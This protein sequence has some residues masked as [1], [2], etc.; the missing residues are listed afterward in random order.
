MKRLP[1]H[2][3][4]T[5]AAVLT[6]AALLVF[7]AGCGGNGGAAPPTPTVTVTAPPGTSST[8]EVPSSPAETSPP[9]GQPPSA[10]QSQAIWE[11]IL[12]R[13]LAEPE[14]AP[15]RGLDIQSQGIKV[16]ADGSD[17]VTAVTLFNDEAALGYGVSG[18]TYRAYAGVLP[19]GLT[20]SSTDSDVLGTM[21]P[22][23]EAYT[24][25]WGVRENFTYRNYDNLGYD[26][27][28]E[29]Q[30]G[31]QREEGTSPIHFIRVQQSG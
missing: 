21:G 22:P 24:A 3:T 1:L 17:T 26:I 11:Q 20:W 16:E 28:I 10:G 8:P 25:G 13:N 31:M 14:L 30:A 2:F 7:L 23:T 27:Y 29:F 12:G 19:G 18:T 5:S 9:S 15:Y 4:T 6:V